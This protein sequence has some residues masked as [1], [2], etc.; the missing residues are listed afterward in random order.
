MKGAGI[1]VTPEEENQ[2]IAAAQAQVDHWQDEVDRLAPE[3][4]A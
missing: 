4:A 2:I 1:K 3:N